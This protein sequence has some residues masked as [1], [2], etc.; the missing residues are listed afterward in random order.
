MLER[1]RRY[2][3][4]LLGEEISDEEIREDS[5]EELNFGEEVT[6][7]AT[8][9]IEEDNNSRVVREGNEVNEEEVEEEID[10]DVIAR[11]LAGE[12]HSK[13][14]DHNVYQKT[15]KT[16]KSRKR[17]FSLQDK[18]GKVVKKVIQKEITKIC[19]PEH[20]KRG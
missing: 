18:R 13:K 17:R 4:A 20:I 10:E 19:T 11:F 16:R 15:N 12:Y 2:L 9:E 3:K 6:E 14:P 8:V 1:Q 5:E 7:E